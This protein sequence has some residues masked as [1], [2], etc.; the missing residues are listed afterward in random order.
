MTEVKQ[1]K[2]R[3]RQLYES[4]VAGLACGNAARTPPV[5]TCFTR[6]RRHLRAPLS[7][8]DDITLC[9]VIEYAPRIQKPQPNRDQMDRSIY[10]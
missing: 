8:R 6:I 10:A 4:E 3:E 7:A 9:L 1:K 5:C 2:Q